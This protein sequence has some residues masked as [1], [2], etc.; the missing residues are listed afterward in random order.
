VA[1]QIKEL[2]VNLAE[3]DTI[4]K[5]KTK[6]TNVVPKEEVQWYASCRKVQVVTAVAPSGQDCAALR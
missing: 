6:A 2:K 5:I 4:W 1:E 3:L